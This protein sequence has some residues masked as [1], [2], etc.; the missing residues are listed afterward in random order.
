MRRFKHSN[1]INVGNNHRLLCPCCLDGRNE[2]YVMQIDE[3]SKCYVCPSCKYYVPHNL[4][5]ITDSQLEAGNEVDATRPY[6]KTVDF[7][8]KRTV[9]INSASSYNNPMDAWTSEA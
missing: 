3:A 1:F 2:E 9:R 6:G 4:E 5:P 8:K 7:V